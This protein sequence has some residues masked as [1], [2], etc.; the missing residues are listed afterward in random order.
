MEEQRFPFLM[1]VIFKPDSGVGR[2]GESRGPPVPDCEL[3]TQRLLAF[4]Q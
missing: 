2:A 3:H 4:L 1:K